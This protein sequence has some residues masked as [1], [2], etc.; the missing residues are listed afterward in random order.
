[1]PGT[2]LLPGSLPSDA[3]TLKALCAGL[4]LI[5]DVAA[6]LSGASADECTGSWSDAE[7]DALQCAGDLDHGARLAFQHPER[8]NATPQQQFALATP[9]HAAL[10]LTDLTVVDSSMLSLTEE[11]SRALCAAANVHL[12]QD[13]VQLHFVDTY[14]WLAC[15]ERAIDVLTERPD[16]L[17]GEAL[18]PNLP[19]GKDGRVV[20]RWMNEL[21]M[22]L[23]THPVNLAR[24]DRGLLPINVVWL[25][26]FGGSPNSPSPSPQPLSPRGLGAIC[27]EFAFAE[28]LRNG[29]LPA[30]QAAWATLAPRILAAD[31]IILGDTQPRIRLQRTQ[32]ST[33]S[34][35]FA[36]FK[37]KPTL[38]N[39]L[40]A[41]HAKSAL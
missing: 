17:V 1:M 21:Q 36:N 7:R 18:R 26:G 32:P 34:R 19:R 29:N 35:F 30:W 27:A 37:A 25:W 39:A 22:L 4:P 13:G 10:G 6:L 33:L 12:H 28:A 38:A 8:L 11:D 2:L 5:G 15:S 24:E 41:L 23:Y 14:R 20:E 31:T 40:M 3:A 16:Y 9:L